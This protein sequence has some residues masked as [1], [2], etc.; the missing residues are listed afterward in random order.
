MNDQIQLLKWMLEDVRKETLEGVKH[1]TKEQ[2]FQNPIEGEFPIGA[3]LMHFAEVDVSWLE[4]L[5]GHE[6][7]EDLK[8]KSYYDKWFDPS[9]ESSPPKE[10]IE[11][12]EYLETIA[13]ARKNFLDYISTLKDSDLEENVIR[14]GKSGERKILKKWII[15]HI[16]EHEA[17]HRG[18]MF[19]LIRKA[20]WNKKK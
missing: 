12:K 7:P 13:M 4:I 10:P 1:L 18:Q 15:Y 14:Q 2:L 3:Y 17:H 8:K 19:M 6:Q 20:G 9:E 16:L 11:I 5:S